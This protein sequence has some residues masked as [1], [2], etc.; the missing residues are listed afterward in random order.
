MIGSR[1]LNSPFGCVSC[2]CVRSCASTRTCRLFTLLCPGGRLMV[3]DYCTGDAPPSPG[4]QAYV[5]QRGY[6]LVTPAAYG[7]LIRAA[8]FEDVIVD[9][10]T[11][12]VG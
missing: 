8:G 3:T 12:Q 11:A 7:D 4:F 6:K 9:D 10:R 1:C 5:K 2:N